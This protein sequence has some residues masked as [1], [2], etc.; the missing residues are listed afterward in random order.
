MAEEKNFKDK[1]EE[2]EKLGTEEKNDGE[3]TM[4]VGLGRKEVLEES[5]KPFWS[6]LRICLL[7][8]FWISWLALLI[9]GALTVVSSVSECNSS[10]S[11]ADAVKNATVNNSTDPKTA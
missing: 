1:Q 3:D 2:F 8:L 5:N 4:F 11:G 6:R 7:V 9:G 10:D